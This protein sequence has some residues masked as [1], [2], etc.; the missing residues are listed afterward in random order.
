[1]KILF[2]MLGL[3]FSL[4][5]L[6]ALAN[7]EIVS[8]VAT[9]KADCP[10][11]KTDE[12]AHKCVEKKGRLNKDFRKSKCWEVNEEYEKKAAASKVEEKK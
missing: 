9:C 1:M 5:H 8:L 12:E 4:S 11:A 3:T 7:E 10:K 2:V 6:Q